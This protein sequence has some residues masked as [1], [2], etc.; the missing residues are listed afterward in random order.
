MDALTDCLKMPEHEERVYFMCS[1]LPTPVLLPA[2]QEEV[3]RGLNVVLSPADGQSLEKWDSCPDPSEPVTKA[4]AAQSCCS[5]G[6][7]P[8]SPSLQDAVGA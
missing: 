4:G 8:P 6:L 2:S 7:P 3:E 1:P 5:M